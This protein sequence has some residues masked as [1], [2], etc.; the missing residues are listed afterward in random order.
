[1]KFLLRLFNTLYYL[2]Y[3]KSSCLL[4]SCVISIG[5]RVVPHNLGDDLNFVLFD[6]SGKRFVN[7]RQTFLKNK[8]NYL[9]I[10]SIIES[11]ADQFS[12]IWGSGAMHGNAK[13]KH[14]PLKVLAVRGPLTRKYLIEQGIDCPEI[15]GDPALLLPRIYNKEVLKKYKVGIIPH[16]TDLSLKQ[17]NDLSSDY[18][19]IRLDKYRLWTDVIDEIRSCEFIVSS[20]LHGLIISDAYNIPNIWVEFKPLNG[21]NRFKFFDYFASVS[22]SQSYPYQ[23]KAASDIHAVLKLDVEYKPIAIDLSPLLDVCP[24]K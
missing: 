17:V 20:S 10:G 18:K 7:Y 13:L 1:M 8:I 15:Y 2:M 23:I 14:K 9:C 22:R 24:F 11:Y 3:H 21:G 6:S 19:I 16:I 12:I 4:K 5:S